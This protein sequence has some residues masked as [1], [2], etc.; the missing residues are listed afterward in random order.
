M[1][2]LHTLRPTTYRGTTYA[3]LVFD[4][5]PDGVEYAYFS[6]RAALM[7]RYDVLHAH[8]PELLVRDTRRPWLRVV[9]R[10][11]LDVLLLRLRSR[12][13]PLVWTAH[14]VK[15]HEDG[16]AAEHRVLERFA[17]QVDVSLTMTGASPVRV[18]RERVMIPH[19]H[20][21]HLYGHAL[22]T[23]APDAV[24]GRLLHFGIIRPYKGVE[25]LLAA[26]ED[27]EV[28]GATLHVAG[29]PHPGQA[30]L[31]VA[32]VARDPR[33]TAVL[34][35]LADDELATEILRSQ[36]V[37]LPYRGQMH[38]SGTLLAALS[39]GRPVLV[40]RSPTNTALAQTV[41]PEW[42]IQYDGDL[43]AST[44]SEALAQTAG[45]S[46]RTPD[47]SA[48]DPDVVASAHLAVYRR[49]LSGSRRR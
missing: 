15:P 21:R 23:A 25:G 35:Y 33:V 11:L 20:Y 44:L 26:F 18:G 49:L 4:R 34:R 14:N 29:H 43:S 22:P 3:D 7:G 27:V 8:W 2:V 42:I 32:V 37:V 48:H 13:I 38:N 5:V 24:P 9:R 6:W 41:G 36:L 10:R 30:A 47:L 17:K 31:V 40:P 39:L 12:G 46:A 16:P 19:A 45:S 28:P 1:R